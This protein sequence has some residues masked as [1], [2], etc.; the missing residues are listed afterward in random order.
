MA[1]AG[2]GSPVE[3]NEVMYPGQVNKI[4]FTILNNKAQVKVKLQVVR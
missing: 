1:Q 4:V 2:V 3:L